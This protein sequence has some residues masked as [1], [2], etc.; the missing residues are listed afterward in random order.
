VGTVQTARSVEVDCGQVRDDTAHIPPPIEMKPE[1]KILDAVASLQEASNLK[2]QQVEAKGLINEVARIHYHLVGL[3]RPADGGCPAKGYGVIL[4]TF[5]LSQPAGL[6]TAGFTPIESDSL[7][8][9]LAAKSGTLA[10]AKAAIPS[11]DVVHLPSARDALVLPGQVSVRQVRPRFQM[12][13]YA[14]PK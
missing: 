6:L 10:L 7:F 3:D 1:Q 14:K 8:V 4:V 9:A 5:I 13:H 11:I 2:E 12:Q